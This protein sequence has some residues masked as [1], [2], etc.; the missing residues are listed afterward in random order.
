MDIKINLTQTAKAILI[1]KNK[2]GGI[3]LPD[4]KLYYKAMVIKTAYHKGLISNIY[5]Q[6]IQL[7]LKKQTAQLKM[8][9]GSEW[10]SSQS[11]QQMASRYMKMCSASLIIKEMEI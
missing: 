7:K 1:R 11:I 8:D 10:T 2:A 6:L 4:F 3:T 5:E 9:K